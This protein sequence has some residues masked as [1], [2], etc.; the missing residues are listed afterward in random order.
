M[1]IG[2]QLEYRPDTLHDRETGRTYAWDPDAVELLGLFDPY[3]SRLG[4]PQRGPLSEERVV[5][6]RVD[7]ADD[8]GVHEYVVVDSSM[9]EVA[10]FDLPENAYIS[11]WNLDGDRILAA[12][13]IIDLS[14]GNTVALDQPDDAPRPAPSGEWF[15]R[16]LLEGFPTNRTLAD[17]REPGS[18]HAERY[19]WGSGELLAEITVDCYVGS[20]AAPRLSP[21]GRLFAAATQV[22]HCCERGEWFYPSLTTISIFDAASGAELLRIGGATF[23]F[24]SD[25]ASWLADSSGLVLETVLGLQIATMDGQWIAL[26]HSLSLGRLRE[27]RP[28]PVDPALFIDDYD[29]Y[30]HAVVDLSGEVVA[31][32]NFD[33][34]ILPYGA[35]SPS[36]RELRLQPGLAGTG[37]P[38]LIESSILPAIQTP[39]FDDAL[40]AEVVVDTC[41]NVRAEATTESEIVVCLPPERVVELVAHPTDGHLLEGPCVED[42]L[43]GNCVWVHV[44][45]ED[46]EQG[47]AYADFLRWSGI[48]LAP[49]PDPPA[50]RG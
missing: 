45:T 1:A 21:D 48:P 40:T 50:P 12:G 36:G 28:S 20:G 19:D 7:V 18:C 14:T 44:L 35:W 4:V 5:F 15:G 39:P 2:P 29:V 34:S 37:T 47:W 25:T 43:Y 22:L 38:P 16:I 32:P 17:D 33:E 31:A 3:W 11:R 8:V 23:P 27:L 30:S 10:T 46:G 13:H 49:D 26:P 9:T 41:L 24:G 42:D 6:R